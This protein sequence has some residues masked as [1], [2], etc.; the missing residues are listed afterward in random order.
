MNLALRTK[1]F[2]RGGKQPELFLLLKKL[3]TTF[4]PISIISNFAKVFEHI[5][6]PV[7]YNNVRHH[8]VMNQH[9]FMN[10]RDTFIITYLA[11]FTQEIS[12]VLDRQG[13]VDVTYLDFSPAFD[14]ISHAIFLHK[15]D[16]LGI[17][18][19]FLELFN[20]FSSR[21]FISRPVFLKVQI[22][23]RRFSTIS[24]MIYCYLSNAL[25][26]LLLMI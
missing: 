5:L 18:F 10:S 7:I 13:Q 4:K 16:N 1:T 23:A 2:P 3:S 11:V 19:L 17:S 14:S 20:G 6:Y 9:S 12:E 24:L 25:V 26:L 8:I 15:L 22:L 21:E